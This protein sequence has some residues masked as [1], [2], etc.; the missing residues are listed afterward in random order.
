MVS[1]PFP[2][3]RERQTELVP[4]GRSGPAGE[5]CRGERAPCPTD[6]GPRTRR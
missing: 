6:S 5:R 1:A 2:W 4:A 3:L